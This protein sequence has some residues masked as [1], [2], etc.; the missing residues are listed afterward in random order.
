MAGVPVDFLFNSIQKQ[1]QSQHLRNRVRPSE[2]PPT[3]SVVLCFPCTLTSIN[4]KP[5]VR[6]LLEDP[7]FLLKDNVERFHATCWELANPA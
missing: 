5:D 1:V 7:I 6:N 3:G 2:Q 4:M